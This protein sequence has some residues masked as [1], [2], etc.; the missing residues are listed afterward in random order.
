MRVSEPIRPYQPGFSVP[1]S[2]IYWAVHHDHRPNHAIVAL[3]TEMFPECRQCHG[4][5]RFFLAQRLRHFA[6]DWDFMGPDLAL[7]EQK[8]RKK[9]A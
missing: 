1:E 3:K 8:D 4:Q 6:Q 9:A 5:V 2:G 7:M